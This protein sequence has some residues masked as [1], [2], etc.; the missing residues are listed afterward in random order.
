MTFTD[1]EHMLNYNY[2]VFVNG[3][4]KAFCRGWEAK[5]ATLRLLFG[6]SERLPEGVVV[7]ETR[8]VF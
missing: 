2:E 8:R 7:H 1:K 6:K 3:V 5:E 4:S